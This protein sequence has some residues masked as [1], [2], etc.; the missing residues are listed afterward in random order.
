MYSIKP[1]FKYSNLNKETF[2]QSTCLLTISVGQEVHEGEKFAATLDLVS[3]TF[4]SAILLI[5]D[6]LQR[7]SMALATNEH[8]SLFY[9]LSILEGD[10]WLARNQQYYQSLDILKTII[11]WDKWL[12]HPNYQTQQQTIQ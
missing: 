4:G 6:S 12:D 1:V 9:G 5:D 7:H 3:A 8:A 10:R 2:K 11:R